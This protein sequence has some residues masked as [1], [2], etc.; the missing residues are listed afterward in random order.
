MNEL[1]E[2]AA[3]VEDYIAHRDELWKQLT[4]D[5]YPSMAD[6]RQLRIRNIICIGVLQR[7]ATLAEADLIGVFGSLAKERL[8]VEILRCNVCTAFIEI[9]I[10]EIAG[11]AR[12]GIVSVVSM[13][14]GGH[15]LCARPTA[16]GGSCSWT[17]AG[18]GPG[19]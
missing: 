8:A 7:L 16:I 11:R 4:P 3:R 18:G 14:G 15:T 12:R 1:S 6:V 5:E 10:K 13:E 2:S 9:C 19:P 17:A